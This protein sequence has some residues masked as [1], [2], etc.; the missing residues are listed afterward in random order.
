M[1]SKKLFHKYLNKTFVALAAALSSSGI[2]SSQANHSTLTDIPAPEPVP[3]TTKSAARFLSQSTM[4][5]SPNDLQLVTSMGINEWLQLQIRKPATKTEPYIKNIQHRFGKDKTTAKRDLAYHKVNARQTNVGYKNF[6]TAWMRAVINGPDQLRQ[7]V[8]WALSQ[9]LVTSNRTNTLTRGTANYYD[10]LLE[11]AFDDY[12]QLLTNVTFHPI[13]GRYLSYLGNKKARPKKNLFPD[14]NYAREIMQ[15]F[16]IGLWEL[17][18]DGTKRLDKYGE[19]IPTYSNNDVVE[20]ARIFTG[21]TLHGE[22]SR[23]STWEKYHVPMDIHRREHDTGHKQALSGNINIPANMPPEEEIQLAISQLVVHPNTAPFIVTRLINH[24]VTSNPSPQYVR[25]VVEEWENTSGNLGSVV[26]AILT[27]R[28]SRNEKYYQSVSYGRLKEP[29]LRLTSFLRAFLCGQISSD[30][31]YKVEGPQ[32]WTP[33]PLEYLYQAPL[34]ATSVFSFFEPDYKKPGL[35]ADRSLYSPEFQILHDS[36]VLAMANYFWLGLNKGF[37]HGANI[38]PTSQLNC[39]FSSYFSLPPKE[40]IAQLDLL[41]T[42]SSMKSEVKK[43]L[44]M[45]SSAF[46]D[47][48]ERIRQTIY[49]VL[50]SPEAA[51]QR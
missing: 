12:E 5:F 41:L 2:V 47:P 28:E 16:S 38:H 21:F 42:A 35:I 4:G 3:I 24:L 20:L 40:L 37:H 8:A 36:S 31:L 13:M 39:D 43:L 6:G 22:R 32:W 10:L 27:D 33:D 44:A 1:A 25:R 49:S 34:R 30:N 18:K 14:E 29:L 48:Q 46:D 26:K 9:I 15:L 45:R 19:A 50:L 11:H 51:I 17:N 7:R 23:M